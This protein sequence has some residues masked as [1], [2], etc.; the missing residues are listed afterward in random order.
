M[1]GVDSKRGVLML[2]PENLKVVGLDTDDGE[3]HVLY[4]AR[5]ELPI[6]DGL[7]Q[8]I[9]RLGVLEPVIV[10]Q[11]GD[12]YIVIDGRQRVR[13]ARE[14]NSRLKERCGG[15]L[16]DHDK[17]KVPIVVKLGEKNS[18]LPMMVA[19]NEF[20]TDNTVMN[21]ARIAAKMLDKGHDGES[22]CEYFGVV[23]Q[24]LDGWIK[25]VSLIDEVKAAVESGKV[26]SNRAVS[27]CFGKSREEQLAFLER[28]EK[29]AK[30]GRPSAPSRKT[31]KHI[32]NELSGLEEN[33]GFHDDFLRG[34]QFA[35]GDL[36][37]EE[38]GL[39]HMVPRRGRKP[40]AAV[41]QKPAE[42]TVAQEELFD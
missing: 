17:I 38:L 16:T 28:L 40:K 11:D 2:D 21:R 18:L 12:E 42:R 32:C 14:A 3:D 15:E 39:S 26:A 24:T 23:A 35:L 19:A 41:E 25:L 37:A 22:V 1:G 6:D 13:S 34:I 36:K 20:R 8:S 4:D 31:L 10:K 9:I 27:V 29:P 5:I 7:V 30:A 33:G